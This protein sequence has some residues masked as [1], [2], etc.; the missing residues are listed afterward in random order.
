MQISRKHPLK[1][2]DWKVDFNKWFDRDDT[3]NQAT[4]DI[5]IP[6]GYLAQDASPLRAVLTQWTERTV[7]VWLDGGTL[8]TI[9]EVCV[10]A[11][12]TLKPAGLEVGRK[13]PYCFRIEID[14]D[15]F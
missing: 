15:V 14:N 1:R 7:T 12:G 9:Y 11:E 4:V 2:A 8:D 10:T 5:T 13:V 3:I 6:N